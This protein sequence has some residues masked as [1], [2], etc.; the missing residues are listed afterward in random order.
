MAWRSMELF[1]VGAYQGALLCGHHFSTSRSRTLPT[2]VE[3]VSDTSDRHGGAIRASGLLPGWIST[4]LRIVVFLIFCCYGWLLFRAHSFDQ[5]K[6][7]TALLFG[8][9]AGGPS[10]ISKPTI[11]HPSASL[12]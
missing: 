8:L 5:I 9:S 4:P 6:T 7:F 10:V 2:S 11:A 12:Y 1:A 3:A